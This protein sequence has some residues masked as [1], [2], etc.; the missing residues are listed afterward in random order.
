MFGCGLPPRL[1]ATTTKTTTGAFL[2]ALADALEAVREEG[3]ESADQAERAAF[4][5]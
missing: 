1:V 3:D 2:A 5:A 4:G